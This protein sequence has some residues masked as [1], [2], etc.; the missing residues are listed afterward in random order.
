MFTVM[1]VRE[2]LAANDYRDPSPYKN[3]EG[4]V[5]HEVQ[6]TVPGDAPRRTDNPPTRAPAAQSGKPGVKPSSSHQH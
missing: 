4:T 6:G 3:P 5:A 1:K 2:G